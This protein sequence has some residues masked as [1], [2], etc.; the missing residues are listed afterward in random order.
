MEDDPHFHVGAAVSRELVP[1][2]VVEADTNLF[3]SLQKRIL[4]LGKGDPKAGLERTLDALKGL[5]GTI[6]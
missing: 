5:R 4:E 2:L 6:K 1:G 3:E